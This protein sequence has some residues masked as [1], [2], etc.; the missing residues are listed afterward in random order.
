MKLKTSKMTP[1]QK[2]EQKRGSRFI[3]IIFAPDYANY[4]ASGQATNHQYDTQKRRVK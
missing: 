4:L 3:R 2:K 1:D